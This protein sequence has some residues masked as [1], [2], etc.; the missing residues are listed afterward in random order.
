MM[1]ENYYARMCFTH[2]C[3]QNT[4]TYMLCE[5][6]QMLIVHYL[7]NISYTHKH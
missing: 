3:M 6:T 4:Y 1:Q 5:H 7:E 2:T